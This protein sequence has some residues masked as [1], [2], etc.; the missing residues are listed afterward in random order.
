MLRYRHDA[1][2][3]QRMSRY[4]LP[5]LALGAL[6][7]ACSA[8]ATV[9]PPGAPTAAADPAATALPDAVPTS[10]DPGVLTLRVTPNITA[11]PA[12]LQKRFDALTNALRQPIPVI[13]LSDGL[14]AN[15]RIAQELAIRD[16]RFRQYVL[17]R[18]GQPLRNEVFQVV[19][20]RAS[21]ITEQSQ[22]CRTN[23]CMRVE[24]YNYAYNLTMVAIVDVVAKQTVAVGVQAQMQPDVPPHLA[25]LATQIAINAPEVQEAL[26]FKPGE[27]DAL[28]AST[29]TSLNRSRCERAQHLCVAPTFVKGDR[30]LW[31]IVDLTDNTLV[32][33][34]WTNVGK[35]GLAVTERKLQNVNLTE[36]YCEKETPL[37]RNG[38][39]L[40]FILTSSDGLRV[41]NVSHNG[42][43]VLRSAKM[44]DWHVSY[45]NTDGFGYSDAVGCPYFSQSAVIAIE[46]PQIADIVKD[47]AVV[48]FS[49][50][51][52]F[53]SEGWPTPCNYNYRQR[54]EFYA[55]GRFRPMVASVGRGCGDDGTYRPV[56]RV[57]LSG[58]Q[59]SFAEWTGSDWKTWT[60]EQWQVYSADSAFTPE[61]YRY[62]LADASGAGF[63]VEPS[64]GQFGDGGRGD[65]AWTYVTRH[66][67]GRDEGDADLIT[68]GPC[69]N[70]DY[71]Q[72]PEKFIEPAPEPIENASLVLWY[73]PQLKNDD[74]PG[75]EY[76]WADAVLANGIY[77]PREFPCYAGP[78]FVPTK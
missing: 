36:L 35:T 19:P 2:I 75:R 24:M 18:D 78:M 33:V 32:G 4:F 47:G 50:E 45:S 69:C 66:E 13:T 73:V 53:Q 23:T 38:W 46:P 59:N 5:L 65:F 8:P 56:L 55:D 76:C 28:M 1:K 16:E 9:A 64:R 7:A 31:A 68:V 48:G 62:R 26:G 63:Y 11:P 22:S 70:T 51:Q 12:Y 74:T 67:A 25:E 52:R 34:R 60:S 72:G 21:D 58:E 40:N 44:V 61:G 42:K 30:A 17:A 29:K 20:A 15:Q 54:Y 14:D 39:T 43:P 27:Q 49:I 57:A 71:R 10:A 41:S 3:T 77:S 37:E 6:I